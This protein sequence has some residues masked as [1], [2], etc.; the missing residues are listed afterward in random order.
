MICG[1]CK[2]IMNRKKFKKIC[3]GMYWR[4]TTTT[5][6]KYQNRQCLRQNSFF[7]GL[8]LFFLKIM[9][10][11]IRWPQNVPKQITLESLNLDKKTYKKIIK[12]VFDGIIGSISEKTS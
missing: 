10:V 6:I 5:C 3:D 8:N 1:G 9:K 11:L 12:K 7:D 4:C 2:S